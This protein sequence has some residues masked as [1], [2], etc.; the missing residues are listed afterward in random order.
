MVQWGDGFGT[1]YDIARRQG[2][3][4]SFTGTIASKAWPIEPVLLG[5]G[6]FRWQVMQAKGGPVIATSEIFILPVSM[7]DIV[8]IQMSEK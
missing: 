7:G 1:W 2:S 6:I 3:F 5:R 8:T 4:D